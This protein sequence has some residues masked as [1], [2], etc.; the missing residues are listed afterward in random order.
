M[1]ASFQNQHSSQRPETVHLATPD[2]EFAFQSIYNQHRHCVYHVALRYLKSAES[3]QEVVQDVFIKLWAER[4]N[5]NM[6]ASVEAWLYQVAKINTLNRLKKTATTTH[7]KQQV[8][9]NTKW[10]KSI[11]SN[12][13]SEC[14]SNIH[15][16][17][18]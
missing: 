6:D 9:V 8:V 5:I 2:S 11:R 3:A 14:D 17:Y 1:L 12:C 10:L 13:C 18:L 16:F 4:K 7:L 15:E